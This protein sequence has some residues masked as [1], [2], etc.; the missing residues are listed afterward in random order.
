MTT[1]RACSVLASVFVA[2]LL[3]DL[4]GQPQEPPR[5]APT[6]SGF[7]AGQV[8]D[9]AS[10]KP[11]PEA[12]V[13]MSGRGMAPAAPIAAGMRGS[14]GVSRSVLADAQGRFFFGS[15]APGAYTITA[16][17]DGY[18]RLPTTPPTTV[19][20]ADGERVTS[21][22]MRLARYASIAGTLR[23]EAGDPVV[24]MDVTAFRRTLVNGRA[25]ML[26]AG[27]ARSDD[28]GV[29]RLARLTP[30]DYFVCACSRDLIPFD[31]TLLTTLAA[32]PLQ[33]LS[34]AGRA[35]STG[36]DA[37]SLDSTLRTF[38]PTLHPN[39]PTLARA[40]RVTVASGEDKIGVDVFL[41]LVRAV[42]VSGRIVG[43]TSAVQSFSMRL[44][45]SSDLGSGELM[46]L[47]PMLV[48]PD[49]RFDFAQVPPGTYRL[50]IVHFDSGVAGGGPSGL[51]LSFTGG[52]GSVPPPPP[53]PPTMSARG[54]GGPAQNLLWADEPI[55]VGDEGL[56]DVI[57]SLNPAVHIRGRFQF[58]GAPPPPG[59]ETLPRAT[60]VFEPIDRMLPAG[61]PLVRALADATIQTTSA[62]PGKYVPTQ[63]GSIPGFPTM[64]SVVVAGADVT[65]LPIDVPE[66]GLDEVV[67]TFSDTPM[68]TIAVKVSAPPN[69]PVTDAFLL[70]FPADQKYWQSPT[71]ARRRFR[72]V[73][74]SSKGAALAA[75]LPAGEY[76]V[77]AVTGQ[78]SIEWQESSR[79]DALS[80]RAQRVTV[81]DGDKRTLEVRR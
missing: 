59:P 50:Q 35:I 72:T 11:I 13:T 4:R 63:A 5:Q 27:R 15:L 71:A 43:A 80:R 10:G 61:A 33:L 58:A 55:T 53:A 39:A 36:S 25:A 32:E 75:D 9:T 64:K 51:A 66:R 48:Q 26:S 56:R 31:Q 14:A 76:F 57:V 12:T 23:D 67:I 1:G 19:D 8:V 16:S 69:Q 81:N 68:A 42:R 65:D 47:Q 17:K 29:Y 34:L 52:R 45:A 49:G 7:I 6:G 3:V 62:V 20:L 40:S 22:A 54:A 77:I 74:V 37:V 30:G 79:L 78:D 60:M 73:A 38:A 41:P 21:L 18:L 2:A 24:A 46:A 28:R 44:V 70:V